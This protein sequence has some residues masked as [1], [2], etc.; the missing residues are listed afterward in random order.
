M[1]QNEKGNTM[2]KSSLLINDPN[3]NRRLARLPE[4]MSFAYQIG[5]T[6]AYRKKRQPKDEYGNPIEVSATN[7][8]R[9][10]KVL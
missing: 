9:P 6:Q 1:M 3:I 4:L 8:W 10:F 2:T 5:T 7:P